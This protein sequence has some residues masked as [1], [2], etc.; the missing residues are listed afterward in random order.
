VSV[1]EDEVMRILV[2]MRNFIPAHEQAVNG[3][4]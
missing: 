2:M 1:A 4:V 3:E